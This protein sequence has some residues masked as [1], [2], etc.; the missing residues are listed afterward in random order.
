M[1]SM[2]PNW[3]KEID[4]QMFSMSSGN[5]CVLG[6]TSN[7]ITNNDD[8]FEGYIDAVNMLSSEGIFT[9]LE[10]NNYGDWVE[11]RILGFIADTDVDFFQLQEAWLKEIAMRL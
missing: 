4:I 1:D 5:Y 6:Q 7:C 8:P 10:Y 3:V 9:R 2:C 11:E